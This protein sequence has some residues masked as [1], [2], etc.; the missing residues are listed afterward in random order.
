[1][2]IRIWGSLKWNFALFCHFP[3]VPNGREQ[4]QSLQPSSPFNFHYVCDSIQSKWVTFLLHFI[5]IFATANFSTLN[6]TGPICLCVSS[7]SKSRYRNLTPINSQRI[8][9]FS[10]LSHHL[11]TPSAVY[12][13]SNFFHKHVERQ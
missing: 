10:P 8:S 4:A 12:S 2:R 13:K 3:A 6:Y 11:T 7:Y 5:Q 1:M 9:S